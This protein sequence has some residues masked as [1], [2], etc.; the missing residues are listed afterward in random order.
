MT[1]R[2]KSRLREQEKKWGKIIVNKKK[3]T[4][5]KASRM[6]KSENKIK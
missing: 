4:I 3:L 6:G 5:T 2:E 1:R